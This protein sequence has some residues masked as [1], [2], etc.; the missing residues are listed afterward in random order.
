VLTHRVHSVWG[1]AEGAHKTSVDTGI[2]VYAVLD[3]L[4]KVGFGLWLLTVQRKTPEAQVEVDGYWSTGLA[5]EG[6]IRIGEP[7]A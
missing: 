4:A 6:R 2:V 1:V 7:D 3:I 5:S